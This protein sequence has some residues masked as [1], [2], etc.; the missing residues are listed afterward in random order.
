M[1]FIPPS[2]PSSSSYKILSNIN[3]Q[4]ANKDIIAKITN[5]ESLRYL[6]WSQLSQLAHSNKKLQAE[7]FWNEK[8]AYLYETFNILGYFS[9]FGNIYC[10]LKYWS[11]LGNE[12]GHS[13]IHFTFES[14]GDSL[15]T[16]EIIFSRYAYV[17][18]MLMS[19]QDRYSQ[20]AIY[21]NNLTALS[22]KTQEMLLG[23][24]DAAVR[25]AKFNS[26]KTSIWAALDS[27]T[28]Q[29]YKNIPELNFLLV[30]PIYL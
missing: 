2:I 7:T 1:L 10:G 13:P 3:P 27:A 12:L 18:A 20:F 8:K 6:F 4:L 25:M 14:S 19:Q 16:V 17:F 5:T 26:Q 29:K 22:D 15:A 28:V 21:K 24:E 11:V 23:V 30:E 9:Q